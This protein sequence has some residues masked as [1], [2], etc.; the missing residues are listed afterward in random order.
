MN[1][2]EFGALKPGDKIV[3][4][5]NNSPGE[6]TGTNAAGVDVVWGPR[7]A[8]ERVFAYT[9]DSTAWFHWRRNDATEG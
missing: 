1:V 7:H 8:N 3:N 4:G 5:M 9:V 2:Q 6:I